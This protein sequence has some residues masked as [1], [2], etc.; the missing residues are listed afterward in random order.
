ML[1]YSDRMSNDN[2]DGTTGFSIDGGLK[3]ASHIRRL[4]AYYGAPMPSVDIAHQ[5]MITAKAI[6]SVHKTEGKE[7]VENLDWTGILAGTR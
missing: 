5:H 3:D 2:F 7:V 4:T 6:H 1:A